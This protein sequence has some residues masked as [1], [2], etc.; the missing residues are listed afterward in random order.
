MFVFISID[1]LVEANLYICVP[2]DTPHELDDS[3]E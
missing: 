1:L 3:Q 2:S